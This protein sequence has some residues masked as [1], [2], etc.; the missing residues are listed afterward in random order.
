MLLTMEKP[1]S[2]DIVLVDEFNAELAALLGQGP[3][4]GG[5]TNT[6]PNLRINYDREVTLD[7]KDWPVPHGAFKVTAPDGNVVYAESIKLRPFLRRYQYM[8]WDPT[9]GKT[10]EGAFVD[11]SIQ[12][13][14]LRQQAFSSLGGVACGKVRGKAAEGPLSSDQQVIQDQ[15]QS[16]TLVY[17]TIDIEG[18]TYD[19]KKVSLKDYPVLFKVRGAN[20]KPLND[21]LD[22]I[23]ASKRL[24]PTTELV[25][26]TEKKKK[27]TTIYFVVNYAYDAK[28]VRPTTA[29]DA[30]LLR[31]FLETIKAENDGIMTKHLKAQKEKSR[32]ADLDD[33]DE[34]IFGGNAKETA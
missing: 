6:L 20:W 19:K 4:L 27:G 12:V 34:S 28:V 18:Q 30:E 16:F 17:G 29:E 11:T 9:A 10:G 23:N 1:L 3:D 8:R 25:L 33:F 26:T 31:N 21:M 22:S 13:A 7:D 2:T 5:N 32:G 15:V 14:D 24:F